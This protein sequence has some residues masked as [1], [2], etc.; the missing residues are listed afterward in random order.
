[1]KNIY[2]GLVT[3]EKSHGENLTEIIEKFGAENQD[4]GA[5]KSS[6]VRVGAAR[7]NIIIKWTLLQAGEA[8]VV[9]LGKRSF[10]LPR[11]LVGKILQKTFKSP[12][13]AKSYLY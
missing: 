7:G 4:L 11:Y 2:Y 1:M 10:S 12:P 9:Q 13:H 6:S 8:R 5:N 3:R